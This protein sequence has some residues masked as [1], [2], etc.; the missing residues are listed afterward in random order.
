MDFFGMLCLRVSAKIDLDCL[1]LFS[2]HR[3][4]ARSTQSVVG[5]YLERGGG[6]G[7]GEVGGFFVDT[8]AAGEGGGAG[9]VLAP[10]GSGR[11]AIV[12]MEGE[13]REE[14]AR[15]ISGDDMSAASEEERD[16]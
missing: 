12:D 14:D 15:S 6:G 13:E 1:R 7:G 9:L 11:G 10:V 5:A 2:E 8:G 16:W 3:G 4:F